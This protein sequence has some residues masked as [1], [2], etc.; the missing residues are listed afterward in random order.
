MNKE[1][2]LNINGGLEAIEQLLASSSNPLVEAIEKIVHKNGGAS[3]INRK[4]KENGSLVNLLDKMGQDKSQYLDDVN[5]LI[6]QRDT[7]NFVKFEDFISNI[8]LE[9]E[10]SNLINNSNAVTLEISWLQVFPCL[11]TQA[12]QAIQNKELMPGRYILGKGMKEQE[13]SGGLLA[14][15]AALNA[16]GVTFVDMLDTNGAADKSNVHLG[17][18]DTLAGYFGGIG[19]PNELPIK[20]IE[21]YLHY[22]M[23]YGVKQVLNINYGTVLAG[24]ILH[25]L[26]VDIEFKL[27]VFLGNDN[28]YSVMMNLLLAK[29]FAREDGS[30]PLN[31][32]NFANS[33][34]NNNIIACSKLRKQFG[35][36][37]Q[38]RFE[39]HILQ[40]YIG[41]VRQPFDR[42][43]ELVELAK[44]VPNIS[45]KHEGGEVEVEKTRAEPSTVFDLFLTEKEIYDQGMLPRVTQAYMDKHNAINKSAKELLKNG[46]SVIAAPNLH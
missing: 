25:N 24:Y 30:T 6:E 15:T 37:N 22:Y 17:G 11:I 33:I 10:T 5:W 38:V 34:N 41:M 20:W 27:S 29:M 7:Q 45:A 46:V 32:L 35:F 23:N 13:Q 4:A 42:R 39:H 2:A 9:A 28:P 3:E 8:G 18:P 40:D 43:D 14:T 1:Q 36:E 21:E 44:S 16:L 26:G 31:G 19:Q 12:K